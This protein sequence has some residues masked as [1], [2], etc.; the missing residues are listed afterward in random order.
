MLFAK[1]WDKK[2]S[3]LYANLASNHWKCLKQL[4]PRLTHGFRPKEF[5]Q[6][7]R[8]CLGKALAGLGLGLE[9]A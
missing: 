6:R 4:F 2:A 7:H 5:G 1:E 3:E 9:W 8:L